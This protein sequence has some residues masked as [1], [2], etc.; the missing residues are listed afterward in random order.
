MPAAGGFNPWKILVP[1]GIAV[2]VTFG[3]FYAWT[4]ISPASSNSQ[5][6]NQPA[7]TLSADPNSQPVQAAQPPTGK[8][9]Q[10]LPSGGS[11]NPAAN[12]NASPNANADEIQTPI[13]DISPTANENANANSNTNANANR[14]PSPLP[15]PTRSVV[16]P[17][18]PPPS[19][20]ATKPPLPTPSL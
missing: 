7:T 18:V 9:E 14:K 4:K 15:E 19:P 11:V 3:A 20:A 6:T 16:P 17:S 10:G 13:A 2:L 12:V 8:A 5:N 1:A